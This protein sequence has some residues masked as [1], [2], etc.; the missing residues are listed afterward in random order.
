MQLNTTKHT[1]A[2]KLFSSLCLYLGF[3]KRETNYIHK[4]STRADKVLRSVR[5][6]YGT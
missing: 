3:C 5:F 6:T 4:P 1:T 2:L